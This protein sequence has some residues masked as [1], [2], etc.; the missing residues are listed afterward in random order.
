MKPSDDP[1]APP[2]ILGILNLTT[3]SFSDGGRFLDPQVALE[4]AEQMLAQGADII[5][6]GAESSHPA[7]ESVSPELQIQRLRPVVEALKSR[8]ARVSVDATYPRVIEAMLRLGVDYI[9]HVDGFRDPQAIA[10]VAGSAAKLIVMHAVAGYRQPG[11]RSLP[12]TPIMPG[13]LTFLR[14]RMDALVAAGVAL[15]RIIV[16]PGM[17]RFLSPSPNPSLE[18]LRGLPELLALGF[19]VCLCASRK[20]FIG[21]VL[22]APGAPRPVD[23]REFGTLAV[24]LWAALGGVQFIRTHDVRALKDALTMLAA[25]GAF[26]RTIAAGG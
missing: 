4:H 17:G 1:V 6:V 5:D 3:D 8:G 14:E 21:A 9:N 26:E 2:L 12:A 19:P 20:S 16:D 13:V 10:A 24:E 25:I 18:V 22:A 11:R 23:Q 7:A 15:E